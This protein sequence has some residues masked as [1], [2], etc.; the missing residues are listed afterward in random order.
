MLSPPLRLSGDD[1][2]PEHEEENGV[3]T[4]GSGDLGRWSQVLF[5]RLVDG[6]L[7]LMTAVRQCPQLSQWGQAT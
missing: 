7:W 2:V 6:K 1:D 4:K 5:L 3:E